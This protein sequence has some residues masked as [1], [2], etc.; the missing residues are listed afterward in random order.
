MSLSRFTLLISLGLAFLSPAL[1]AAGLTLEQALQQ[2]VQAYPALAAQQ[3]RVDAARLNQIPADQLPDPK[4]GVGIDNFP[5]SGPMA[6]SLTADF[7]TMQRISVMQEVPNADKRRARRASADARVAQASAE[8]LALR[9]E[10]RRDTALAWIA[11]LKAEKKLVWFDQ[12][13][14]ENRR[15][16]ETVRARIASGQARVDEAVMP[17]QEALKLADQRDEL[18][19]QRQQAVAGLQRWLGRTG[20][21]PLDPTWPSWPISG[22]ALLAHVQHHPELRVF[23][24]RAQVLAAEQREAEAAKHPDWGVELA[25]QHRGQQFGDM[26]SLGFT[27]DL[28]IFSARRQ[29]PRI[30][31][32]QAERVGLAAERE[33]LL[34]RHT[35]ELERDLAEYDRLD[36]A[37]TRQRDALLPLL[38]SKLHLLQAGY[39][40]DKASLVEIMAARAESRAA[41]LQLIELEGQ[42][43][44]TAARLHFGYG[45]D[46]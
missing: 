29:D 20:S 21:A 12:L 11:R 34:R 26:V 9:R 8:Q 2:A 16:A 23:E 40:A 39:S 46:E 31:A 45:E 14:Q 44:I 41:Q 38:A 42:R 13:E 1:S 4:L 22:N 17:K 24:P 5:I 6:N 3:A 33:D 30:A 35:E 15:L 36:R 19:A 32:K 27:F 25:Y 10:V 18:E 37:L 43:S 7:M 28:P